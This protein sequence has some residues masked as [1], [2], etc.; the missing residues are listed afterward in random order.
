MQAHPQQQPKKRSRILVVDRQPSVRDLL[1]ERLS[2]LGFK[3]VEA[4]SVE[5]ALVKISSIPFELIISEIKMVGQSG[6]DLLK[7]VKEM[8]IGAEVIIMTSTPSLESS[9][10]ATRLGAYD[11]LVKPFEDL[12]YLEIVV[13]RALAQNAL[14]L[15]NQALLGQLSQQNEEMTQGSERAADIMLETTRFYKIETCILKSKNKEELVKYLEQG[16]KLLSKGKPGIIW[17]YRHKQGTLEA[18]KTIELGDI[19]LPPISFFHLANISENEAALWLSNEDYKATLNQSLEVIRPKT[20]LSQPMIYQNKWYGLITILNRRPEEWA[21]HE[22]NSLTHMCLLAA[23]KLS[24]F[25]AASKTPQTSTHEKEASK[26]NHQQ[27]KVHDTITPLL[28]FDYFLEYIKLEVARS[29]RYRHIFTLLMLTF[30]PS[31]D[32]EKN[33]FFRTF[34]QEWGESLAQQIRTTDFATRKRNKFY[35]VL[36]ETDLVGSKKIIQS[37]QH[38]IGISNQSEQNSNGPWQGI[39]GSVEYPKDGDTPEVLVTNLKK[40]LQNK[41]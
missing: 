32:P 7:K 24:G 30:K 39:I 13:A 34:I 11:Y 40:R 9:L 31:T 36:P 1:R 28:N 22:K 33:P 18:Y 15:E 25:D 2:R 21:I 14:K 37:L 10:K 29:R 23:T 17:F 16:V 4:P 26:P 19:P 38:Q 41:S 6:I 8:K 5:I 35:I 27:I 3:V 12:E 20:Q